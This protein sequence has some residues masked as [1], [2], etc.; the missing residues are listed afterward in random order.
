M[1]LDGMITDRRNAYRAAGRKLGLLIRHLLHK[2]LNNREESSDFPL[3]RRE[4]VMH[5]FRL[6]GR[7]QRF[8]SAFSAI[9]NLFAPS[10][11]IITALSRHI[12]RVQA[13][14]HWNN[15]TALSVCLFLSADFS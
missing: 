5:K 13:F 7:C 14:A 8:V 1:R 15:A 11:S 3:R 2:G 10:A 4:R 12:D 9:R 6:S